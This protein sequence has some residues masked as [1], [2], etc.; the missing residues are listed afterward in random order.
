MNTKVIKKQIENNHITID[1][2][3][4]IFLLQ[5]E[6]IVTIWS[7]NKNENTRY[8]ATI[9]NYQKNKT[10]ILELY[11][12]KNISRFKKYIPL[13]TYHSA[14]SFMEAYHTILSSKKIK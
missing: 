14:V 6:S 3:I 10:E 5:D 2:I 9:I 4:E 7:T 12:Y 1:K 11:E 8:F 13:T